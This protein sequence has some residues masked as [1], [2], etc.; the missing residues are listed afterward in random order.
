MRSMVEGYGQVV[1]PSQQQDHSRVPLHHPCGMVPLPVPGRI[2][3]P[4]RSTVTGSMAHGNA[5]SPTARWRPTLPSISTATG[6]MRPTPG[7]TRAS[8]RHW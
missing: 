7:S 2:A 8:A 1:L 6:L 3:R 5:S 4:A